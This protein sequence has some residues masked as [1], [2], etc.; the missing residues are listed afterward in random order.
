MGKSIKSIPK[1]ALQQ[2]QQYDWPGNI[3][4]LRNVI[5]RALILSAGDTLRLEV[6]GPPNEGGSAP[7][8][9]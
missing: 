4:E 7:P 1:R 5:E 8:D 6:P 3:R 2:L 9:A